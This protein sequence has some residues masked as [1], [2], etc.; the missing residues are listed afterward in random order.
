MEIHGWTLPR[1]LADIQPVRTGGDNTVPLSSLSSQ[2]HSAGSL[3][4]DKLGSLVRNRTGRTLCN[5]LC[6]QG[7]WLACARPRPEPAH[8]LLTPAPS[9][10]L[11]EPSSLAGLNFRLLVSWVLCMDALSLP[12]DTQQSLL[13]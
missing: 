9:C 11:V 2:E 6:F 8:H 4:L 3:G 1:S 13:L 10:Q 5:F 7:S 12:L